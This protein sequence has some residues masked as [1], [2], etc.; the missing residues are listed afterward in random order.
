MRNK[1]AVH[2][3]QTGS[4]TDLLRSRQLSNK[5]FKKMFEVVKPYEEKIKELWS[6]HQQEIGAFT[7]TRFDVGENTSLIM[8]AVRKAKYPGGY[9]AYHSDR[10]IPIPR[11]TCIR[12]AALYQNVASLGL[13]Q[14]VLN[15]AYAAGIDLI[16]HASKISTAKTEVQEMDG[17]RFV[18]FLQQKTKRIPSP[19]LETVADF[20][21]AGMIA[22]SDI[23]DGIENDEEK[24]QAYAGIAYKIRALAEEAKIASVTSFTVRSPLSNDEL[25]LLLEERQV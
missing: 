5:T 4:I 7:K 17:P 20:V 22:L 8:E 10:N 14:E 11:Q 3:E 1:S 12:Y 23:F 19:K 16:K 21:S 6:R 13:K 2:P 25:E 15:A 9:K 24:N 18:R